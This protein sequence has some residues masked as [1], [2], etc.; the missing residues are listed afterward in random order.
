VVIEDPIPAGCEQV[1]Q[2]G[3][4]DLNYADKDWS[5]FYSAREFRDA[6]TVL[7][8]QNFDG[9]ATFQY[10]MRVQQ[11]GQ[12]R[13]APARVEPM[14]NPTAQANAASATLNILDK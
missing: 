5:D 6:R 9:K 7:F 11:P 13:V 12:F 10:A 2:V 3:G 8:L 4:I 1:E 14:Y